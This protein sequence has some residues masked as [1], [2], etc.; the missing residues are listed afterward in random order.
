MHTSYPPENVNT[1]RPSSLA[2]RRSRRGS[3]PLL[4]ASLA[5]RG[6]VDSQSLL[7][8]SLHRYSWSDSLPRFRPFGVPPPTLL[9]LRFLPQS[10]GFLHSRRFRARSCVDSSSPLPP[11]LASWILHQ[12]F[13][14]RNLLTIS[15]PS[16][17]FCATVRSVRRAYP[18]H[19][20]AP[21]SYQF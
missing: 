14:F 11:R 12:H 6:V 19:R 16:S 7:R 1:G 2:S 18:S 21:F 9:H 20:N 15:F 10:I 4:T 8:R 3:G 13:L 5:V 17:L